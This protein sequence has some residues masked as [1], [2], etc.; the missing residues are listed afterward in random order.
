MRSAGVTQVIMCDDATG[1]AGLDK[2]FGHIN[3]LRRACGSQR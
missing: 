1:T 3:E 2:V